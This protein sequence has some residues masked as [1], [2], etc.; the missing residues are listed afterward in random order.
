[1]LREHS[2][3]DELATAWAELCP[4]AAEGLV[5]LQLAELHVQFAELTLNRALLALI[6]LMKLQRGLL[7]TLLTHRTLNLLVL[8]L[9]VLL[10]VFPGHRLLTLRA[11]DQE[12]QAVS[13][14]EGEV[15]RGYVSFAVLAHREGSFHVLLSGVFQLSFVSCR[16]GNKTES[17]PTAQPAASGREEIL[18]SE[19]SAQDSPLIPVAGPCQEAPLQHG[20]HLLSLSVVILCCY[21]SRI[22][23]PEGG[24][25]RPGA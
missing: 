17:L 2:A 21:H 9:A 15:G 3:H 20:Q 6:G 4:A 12:P 19:F 14:M 8:N 16:Q 7:H 24:S 23:L 25:L 11:Q 5:E 13:L 18:P 1:M 22:Y 10:H